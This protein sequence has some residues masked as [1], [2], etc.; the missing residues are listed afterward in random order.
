MLEAAVALAGIFPCWLLAVVADGLFEE[1]GFRL[2][3]LYALIG[4][5]VLYFVVRFVHWAWMT[6][7]PFVG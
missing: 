1:K 5:A 6:P 3:L 4:A 7:M 2:Y